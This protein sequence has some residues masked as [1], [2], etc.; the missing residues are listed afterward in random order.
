MVTPG[1]LAG[2]SINF[3]GETNTLTGTGLT[4][5]ANFIDFDNSYDGFKFTGSR[6][7]ESSYA[8]YLPDIMNTAN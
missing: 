5:G 7:T 3:D 1:F 8:D 6:S 2:I 4:D